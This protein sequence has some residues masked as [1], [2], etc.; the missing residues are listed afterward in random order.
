MGSGLP[1]GPRTESS[2]TSIELKAAGGHAASRTLSLSAAPAASAAAAS[3]AVPKAAVRNASVK[4]VR[5]CSSMRTMARRARSTCCSGT[6]VRGFQPTGMDRGDWTA[7]GI[8]RGVQSGSSERPVEEPALCSALHR[9]PPALPQLAA[10]GMRDALSGRSAL[11]ALMTWRT[12]NAW[13]SPVLTV[14][15]P[16]D[17]ENRWSPLTS[18]RAHAW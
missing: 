15:P 12:R 6:G 11:S 2:H 13:G 4:A 7:C 16:P 8:A 3:S 5:S 18:R 10:L 9:P 1:G 17:G 14:R